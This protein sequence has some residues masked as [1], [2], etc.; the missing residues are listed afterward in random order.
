MLSRWFRFH[1]S[2]DSSK[3]AI[4]TSSES[5]C[6]LN[7]SDTYCPTCQRH[8]WVDWRSVIS[9]SLFRSLCILPPS[10]HLSLTHS[11]HNPTDFHCPRVLFR[12]S[13]GI[14]WYLLCHPGQY[15]L[16]SSHPIYLLS[17]SSWVDDALVVGR[18][19]TTDRSCKILFFRYSSD[20][21]HPCYQWCVASISS[22][23][24]GRMGW[25]ATYDRPLDLHLIQ[26]TAHIRQSIPPVKKSSWGSFLCDMP[27]YHSFGG[28]TFTIPAF[29]PNASMDSTNNLKSLNSSMVG[30]KIGMVPPFSYSNTSMRYIHMNPC[31]SILL[32][33]RNNYWVLYQVSFSFGSFF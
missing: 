32:L 10:S 6:L 7:T 28:M 18:G 8:T 16:R 13:H 24:E 26:S 17:S 3:K 12:K 30:L 33:D 23:S 5:S 15:S 11:L 9:N 21:R 22:V 20:Q 25:A 31:T 19:E 14:Q 29:L 27:S 4:Q 1:V 2:V